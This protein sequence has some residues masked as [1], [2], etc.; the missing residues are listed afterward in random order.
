MATPITLPSEIEASVRFVEDTPPERVVQATLARL[1][2][3]EAANRAVGGFR[4]RG[5]PLD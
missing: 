5:E 4:H 1:R 2:A 3:G